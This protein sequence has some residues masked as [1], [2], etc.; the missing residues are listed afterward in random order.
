M[1]VVYLATQ[2]ISAIAQHKARQDAERQ[3]R[4]DAGETWLDHDLMFCRE[5]GT[6]LQ[7]DSI[8]DQFDALVAECGLPKIRLH[9]LRH[10]VASLLIARGM[11]I[12]SVAKLTGHDIATLES[13]YHHLVEEVVTPEIQS[14]SDWLEALQEG[15]KPVDGD[16]VAAIHLHR[17]RRAAL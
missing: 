12:H 11:P 7:P 4:I 9:D 15:D 13:I 1:R 16:A 10:N 5:D 3:A 2:H 6:P 17:Q 14:A 8:T